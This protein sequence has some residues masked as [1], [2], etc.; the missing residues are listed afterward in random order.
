MVSCGHCKLERTT[1]YSSGYVKQQD[2]AEAQK[3]NLE[4]TDLEVSSRH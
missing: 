1:G 3:V 2:I 4:D